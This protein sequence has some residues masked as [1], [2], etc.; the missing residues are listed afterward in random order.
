MEGKQGFDGCNFSGSAARL[1]A[2][3]EGGE[4]NKKRDMFG[5]ALFRVLSSGSAWHDARPRVPEVKSLLTPAP[6]GT[7]DLKKETESIT[8]R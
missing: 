6:G 2:T 7:T 5:K 8:L 4:L 3:E 1:Q